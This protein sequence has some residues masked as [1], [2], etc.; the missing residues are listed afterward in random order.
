MKISIITL[1]RLFN[2]GSVLQTY[3][4]QK[5]FENAGYEAEVIDYITPQRTNKR[6]FFGVPNDFNSGSLFKILY[7]SAK[8]FSVLLKKLTFGSFLNK[9]VHLTSEKYIDAKDLDAN[10]PKADIYV[11]G[12]DQVWNSVYNEGIDRGFFL[13]FLPEDATRIAFVSSFGKNK[14]DD[15]EISITKKYLDRYKAISV[16][17]DSAKKIVEDLGISNCVQLIDPTLQVSK[18]EWLEIASKRL[19]K[20]PYLILMLLYNE[21]NN[22][23]KYARKIADE[24]R[25]KLVKICWD[26]KK[27]KEV[28]E[29]FTHRT[30]SDFLSLFAYA[31]FVVTNSFHGLAF[32]VNFERQFIVVP[33]NEFNS[34]IESLLRVT[35][36]ENRMISNE[37]D[38]KKQFKMKI[39]YSNVNKRLEQ[40]REK[41]KKFIGDINNYIN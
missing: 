11:T 26:M 15:N 4:T 25:L 12:S 35:G 41:A 30:P 28:D 22:A 5:I 36:L 18:N 16:R 13:D 1:H 38:L 6:L 19:V 33:R 34:R 29:M 32:S 37:D 10:P 20:E 23:T 31:D 39:D 3:A 27:P 9:Y 24:K 7:L 21:D 40:E 8:F 14:L 2:Y 17:E